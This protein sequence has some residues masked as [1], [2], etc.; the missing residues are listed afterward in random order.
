MQLGLLRPKN[1]FNLRDEIHTLLDRM[2][3]KLSRLQGQSSKSQGQ[4]KRYKQN[5]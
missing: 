1:P 2:Q 4:T 5:L 3:D